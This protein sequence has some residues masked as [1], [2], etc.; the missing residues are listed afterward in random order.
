MGNGNEFKERLRTDEAEI[1]R[2][3]SSARAALLNLGREATPED[4]IAA[5]EDIETEKK[6]HMEKGEHSEREMRIHFAKVEAAYEK[7]HNR[8]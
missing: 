7:A 6:E 1:T 3:D 8:N 4:V 5:I 2:L